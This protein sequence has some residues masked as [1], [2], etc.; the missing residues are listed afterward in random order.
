M[1]SIELSTQSVMKFGCRSHSWYII[2]QKQ[3]MI[4]SQTISRGSTM[5]TIVRLRTCQ[6][7]SVLEAPEGTSLK[8]S[9]I[10]RLQQVKAAHA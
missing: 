2:N 3:D 7:L 8:V 1:A 4:S 5:L 10:R 9:R 6:G